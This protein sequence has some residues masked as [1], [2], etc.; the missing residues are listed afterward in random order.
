[1]LEIVFTELDS[2]AQNSNLLAI[3]IDQWLNPYS[4]QPLS[5]LQIFVYADQY[6]A[7]ESAQTSEVTPPTILSGTLDPSNVQLLSSSKV[8]GA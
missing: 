2:V 4:A 7:S 3:S 5:S 1:M 8:V 6:C